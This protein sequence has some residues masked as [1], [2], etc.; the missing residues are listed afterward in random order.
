MKAQADAQAK[1]TLKI[2]SAA[3]ALNNAELGIE[4]KTNNEADNKSIMSI[5][6]DQLYVSEGDKNEKEVK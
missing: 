5:S 3:A 1:G 2:S 4:V 6:S